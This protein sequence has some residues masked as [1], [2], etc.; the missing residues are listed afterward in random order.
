[1][2]KTLI[3]NKKSKDSTKNAKDTNRKSNAI[4]V[5]PVKRV[6][7]PSSIPS[8][9][10]FTRVLKA[11]FMTNSKS[12]VQNNLEIGLK[13]SEHTPIIHIPEP[14]IIDGKF[15]IRIGGKNYRVFINTKLNEICWSEIASYDYDGKGTELLKNPIHKGL[16]E[17][18]LKDYVELKPPKNT[19]KDTLNKFVRDMLK[20]FKQEDNNLQ[21]K[22][23]SRGQPRKGNLT[24][25]VAW[26]IEHHPEGQE[27][28]TP[29]IT[30]AYKKY[31]GTDIKT[32]F[33]T[34][35]RRKWNEVNAGYANLWKEFKE[36]NPKVS[37]EEFKEQNSKVSYAKKPIKILQNNR[38]QRV[39][40]NEKRF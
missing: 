3:V 23:K 34:M 18:W 1:M 25:A 35:V 6:R 20:L 16:L 2:K 36:Q 4:A 14:Q 15:D 13:T 26:C 40:Q 8:D 11:E 38:K 5:E 37:Y 12:K 28:K 9:T 31:G 10:Q 17:Q 7:I 27:N 30:D 29:T 39:K 33:I 21:L 24:K 19:R 32:S 22:K